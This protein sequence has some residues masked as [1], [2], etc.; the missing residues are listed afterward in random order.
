MSTQARSLMRAPSSAVTSSRHAG[1]GAPAAGE[2]PA[3]ACLHGTR[4]HVTDDAATPRAARH[5]GKHPPF[6]ARTELPGS[7]ASVRE[8]REGG[9]KRWGEGAGG[10]ERLLML[11]A[12]GAERLP[13]AITVR[14]GEAE[15]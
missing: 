12:P 1:G 11:R 7:A 5:G 15:G 10:R 3:R 8:A 13:A 4:G 14:C 6:G 9:G 2:R